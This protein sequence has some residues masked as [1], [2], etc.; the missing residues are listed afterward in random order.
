[1]NIFENDAT[2]LWICIAAIVIATS[3]LAFKADSEREI[4]KRMEIQLKLSQLNATNAVTLK[5]K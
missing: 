5:D 3:Y 4:T 1:M 2:W